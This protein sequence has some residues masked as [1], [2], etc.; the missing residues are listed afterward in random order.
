MITNKF[1]YSLFIHTQLYL[2]LLLQ[3]HL[4]HSSESQGVWHEVLRV[5]LPKSKN[6]FIQQQAALVKL[7]EAKVH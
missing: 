2:V 3:C 4:H 6:P 5:W 7:Y 1:N